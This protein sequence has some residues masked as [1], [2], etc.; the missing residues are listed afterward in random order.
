MADVLPRTV[1]VT[2]SAEI[3]VPADRANVSLG[4]QTTAATAA[5]ALSIIA[6]RADA[7]IGALR[8]AGVDDGDVRTSGLNLWH[9]QQA[10]HYAAGTS[11]DVGCRAGRVGELLDVAATAAGESF[12]LN[13]VSF[14]V[15]EPGSYRAAL[16]VEALRA[17]RESASELADAEGATVGEALTIVEG[18]AAP[19]GHFKTLAMDRAAMPVEPGSTRVDLSVTVTY[20]LR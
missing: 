1:T 11:L 5:E 14:S 15:S 18:G 10:G 13:G 6:Q 8:G 17:A 4:V 9:D 12:S 20:E 2:G 7:L 19:P 16:R 3:A